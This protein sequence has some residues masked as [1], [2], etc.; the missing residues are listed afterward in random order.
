MGELANGDGWEE[1]VDRFFNI[2]PVVALMNLRIH[3][4]FSQP[5]R[6]KRMGIARLGDDATKRK[7]TESAI[8]A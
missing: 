5:R 8:M 1:A 7:G 4:R 3:Y 6:G 2:D